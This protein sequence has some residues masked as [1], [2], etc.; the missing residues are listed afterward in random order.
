MAVSAGREKRQLV[1][2]LRHRQPFDIGPGKPGEPLAGRHFRIHEG[3]HAHEFGGAERTREIDQLLERE[4]GPGDRHA[5]GL[6]A[7]VAIGA[8]LQRQ[9]ADEIVDADLERFLHHAV[10]CHRPRPN[11]QHLRLVGDVLAGAEFVEI[12]VVAVDRLVGDRTVELVFFVALGRIEIG[13][14]V[15]QLGEVARCAAP[16]PRPAA[17]QRAGAPASRLRRLNA[18]C[19]GVARRSGISQPRRRMMFIGA[20][21]LESACKSYGRRPSLANHACGRIPVVPA[22][23]SEGRDPYSVAHREGTAYGSLHS[24]GRRL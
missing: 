11:W 19:S 10:D 18:R 12:V 21:S 20:H 4:P 3:F 15:R 9:F 16:S 5:P 17:G 24:R 22:E 2:R 14:R 7:A 23:R 13:A 6:H 8:L 1:G